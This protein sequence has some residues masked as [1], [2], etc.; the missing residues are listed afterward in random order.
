MPNVKFELFQELKGLH[1][2]QIKPYY[3]IID[4]IDNWWK[5]LIIARWSVSIITFDLNNSIMYPNFFTIHTKPAIS[6]F[7][8]QKNFLIEVSSIERKK[9][10]YTNM[11]NS[12][13]LF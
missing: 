3:K 9:I 12:Q 2:P 4:V 7:V 5:I 8:G 1:N 6:S 11:V 10:N 13:R